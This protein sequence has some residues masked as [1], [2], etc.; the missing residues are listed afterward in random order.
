MH[1]E[2]LRVEENF[3][4]KDLASYL[5]SRVKFFCLFKIFF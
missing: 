5:A 1:R 2:N 4:K 3:P